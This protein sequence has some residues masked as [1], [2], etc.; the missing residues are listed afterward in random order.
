[1]RNKIQATIYNRSSARLYYL[2]PRWHESETDILTKDELIRSNR[3]LEQL[4]QKVQED[5]FLWGKIP[6]ALP[7]HWEEEE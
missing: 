3:E 4:Y 5:D 1:M 2:P 7:D 6:D